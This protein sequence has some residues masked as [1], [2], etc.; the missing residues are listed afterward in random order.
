MTTTTE[1][2]E[3]TCEHCGARIYFRI[4]RAGKWTTDPK[5]PDRWKC[6]TEDKPVRA[7]AP[8]EKAS[9]S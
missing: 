8:T 7:H 4:G 9:V 3:A 5:K 6:P 2:R 1:I